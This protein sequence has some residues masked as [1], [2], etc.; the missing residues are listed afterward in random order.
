MYPVNQITG[1]RKLICC[2]AG[3]QRSFL[4]LFNFSVHFFYFEIQ[5]LR[6]V[7]KHRV[8]LNAT[9]RSICMSFKPNYKFVQTLFRAMP[10]SKCRKRHRKDQISPLALVELE[11]L[12][13]CFSDILNSRKW[14]GLNI[15]GGGG[16]K[17][18]GKNNRKIPRELSFSIFEKS[19]SRI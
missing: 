13:P 12:L 5:L 16:E 10:T 6:V 18:V 8:K 11:F 1:Q 14:E 4:H 17:Y 15:S 19:S 7:T 9:K 3:R 2:R